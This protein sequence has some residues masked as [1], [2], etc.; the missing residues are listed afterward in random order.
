[1]TI[2]R[3]RTRSALRLVEA[4]SFSRR[5][6]RE[7]RSA[8]SPSPLPQAGGAVCFFLARGVAEAW[9]CHSCRRLGEEIAE[10]I[11]AVLPGL[12]AL[13]EP[14]FEQAQGLRLDAALAHAAD[15]AGADQ[16]A[17]FQRLDVLHHGCERHAQRVG[18]FADRGVAQKQALDNGPSRGVGQ[19]AKDAVQRGLMVK[20]GLK[21]CVA[22]H[23]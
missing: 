4:I 7:S 9:A 20:H 6:A 18:E 12:A 15:L 8:L 11:Q 23:R 14:L 3:R 19:C 17:F 2:N 22:V 5:R 1:M 13:R 16:A 21:F 10:T